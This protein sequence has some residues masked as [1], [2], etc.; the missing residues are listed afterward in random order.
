MKKQQY[1]NLKTLPQKKCS[2]SVVVYEIFE[3]VGSRVGSEK[4]WNK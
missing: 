2:E 3:E 1:E 4:F